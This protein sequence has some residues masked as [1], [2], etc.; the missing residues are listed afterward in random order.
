M[1]ESPMASDAD[2]GG[3]VP[4]Q[5]IATVISAAPPIVADEFAASYQE[6][7]VR[8]LDLDT[9]QVG[10]DV[11]ALYDRLEVEIADA[12]KRERQLERQVRETVFPRLRERPNALP[13][14]GV[15]QATP[16]EIRLV[17]QQ[18]LFTGEVEAC[19]GTSVVHD[20]LPVTIVQL[21]VCLAS[22][23]GD[24]GTWSHRMFRREMRA[25]GRDPVEEALD[26]LDARQR[27]AGFG[28]STRQDQL[29][30]L[31]RRGVMAYMERRVLL[32]AATARW[33]MGHG[34]PAPYELITGSGSV[35][36]AQR[37]LELLRRLICDHRRFVFVPSGPADRLLLTIGNALRPLEYAIVDTLEQQLER[38]AQGGYRGVEWG[39]L[40][41]P[42]EDFAKEVGPEVVRGV[43]RAS[44]FA[45][46]HVF[47]AH[48]EF[49]HPA[50]LIA[51]ADGALQEH[52][53]FPMLI[54]LADTVCATT[55]DSNSFVASIEAAYARAGEPHRYFTE[56]QT[57]TR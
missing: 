12:V 16:A 28:T 52:R 1:K 19:D 42:V 34:N 47:Y 25:T 18:Q 10:A 17:H 8:A 9:W 20:T 22:Y 43:Y 32:E 6:P 33:R 35:E 29:T 41:K 57:R 31:A 54:D 24:L 48:R 49:A 50:A 44:A 56:R 55:F 39:G 30:D 4:P 45:P 3:D 36:L 46:A 40:R 26:A 51:M 53:G 13:D 23:Q 21:G 2:H 38:V 14:A 37:S 11:A 27:R 5:D 15:R 7:L